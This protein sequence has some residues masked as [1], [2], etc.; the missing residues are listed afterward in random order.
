[1]LKIGDDRRVPMR[2]IYEMYLGRKTADD[3][4]A[5][6]YVAGLSLFALG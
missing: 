3:V 4:L 2:D 5:G 1:M 6:I